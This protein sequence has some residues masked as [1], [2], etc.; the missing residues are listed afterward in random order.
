MTISAFILAFAFSAGPACGSPL[1]AA[2]HGSDARA[3]R[4]M[5]QLRKAS[6]G[7]ALDHHDAF[8]ETGTVIRD[9]H[10]GTYE[11]Y[12]DLHS[13]RTAGVHTIEGVFGAGGFDGE[14]P[15]RAGSDGKAVYNRDPK[16]AREARSEAY[17][18]VGGYNWPDRFPATFTYVGVRRGEARD[19]DV[20]Q[21]TPEGGAPT[22]L[23]LDRRTHRL[24][25]IT[26][27]SAGETA[28]ADVL[29][30]RRV[31]GVV[32]GFKS[33]QKEAGHV[34]VQTV[35]TYRHVPLEPNRLTPSK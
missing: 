34:M 26:V 28:S 17:F 24:R 18:T 15:W 11:M 31:D 12:G 22:D 2:A 13:V 19:Y 16:A 9:G 30:E 3:L 35:A 6:G 5:A 10:A 27:T 7:P 20:V 25:R 23:W 8:H 29:A 33:R 14:A 32:I 21:V 4:L 1:P